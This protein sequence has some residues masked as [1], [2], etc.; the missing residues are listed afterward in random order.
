MKSESFR[1]SFHFLVLVILTIIQLSFPSHSQAQ[2]QA[3]E[4][5]DWYFT[6]APYMLFP[7]LKGELGLGLLKEDETSMA[8]I[9]TQYNF[10]ITTF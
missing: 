7:S 10:D 2:K 6:I 1:F 8:G 3:K 4:S 9:L 5:N